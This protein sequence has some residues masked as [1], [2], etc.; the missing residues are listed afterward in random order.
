[1]G[2]SLV[3][4][5]DLLPQAPAAAGGATAAEQSGADGAWI[6]PL[7]VDGQGRM[8]AVAVGN[9]ANDHHYPGDDWP[10]A[11]KSCR[12]G[13]RW[14]GTPFVI[15]FGALVSAEV[16][17]LLAADKAISC[18][19]MANGATRLQPLILNI[20]QAAGAAAA[21]CVGSATAPAALDVAALQEAL[22]ADPL[23]PAG[24][25]P[26]W[27]TPWHHPRWRQR[28]RQALADP[29]CL[30]PSGCLRQATPPDPGDAPAEP[31]E[32]AFT[33]TLVPD[34]H[35]GYEL[36]GQ[37]R[38]WPLITLEPGLNLWLGQQSAPRPVRLI[39]VINPWG[40][41]LRVS[42]LDD[43]VISS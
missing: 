14:S 37:D 38:P 21:L 13:G 36:H 34:G 8:T 10:L 4:E 30:E 2:H 31:H 29:S 26:L 24:P 5:Q 20:G 15:P 19:H 1:V 39:G 27:D 40:P 22:I 11:P 41:W 23:A 7:P 42:R 3:V 25:M 9:Y 33:G 16:E 18:T 6:G 12:W 32:Q 43:G 17:N 28:Q 35:G